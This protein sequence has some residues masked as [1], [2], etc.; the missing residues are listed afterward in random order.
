MAAPAFVSYTGHTGNPTTSATVTLPT[1][2]ANDILILVAVNAGAITSLT[3][4]GTYSG[5]AWTSIDSGAGTL[6]WGGFWWSRC[7]GN[8]TG[9]TVTVST[10]VDSCSAAIMRISG[11][12]T[13]GSPIDTNKSG[14]TIAANGMSLTG[15]NTTVA[16]TLVVFGIAADDNITIA[17]PTKGATAMDLRGQTSSTGGA[18]SMVG[19]ATLAQAASGATGNFT[20]NH[21]SA[22][23]KRLAAFA[24]TPPAAA[25]L[26]RAAAI[27]ATGLVATAGTGFSVFERATALSASASA[28]SSGMVERPRAASL[29]ATTG[30]AS[31]PQRDLQRAAA[32]AASSAVTTQ[33]DVEA[34][35]S[36]S[37]SAASQVQSAAQRDL[38]RA[39][40]L[41]AVGAIASAAT[42]W[43]E[44]ERSVL[45]QATG[46]VSTAGQT[47]SGSTAHERSAALGAQGV[48]ATAWML[49]RLRSAAIGAAAGLSATG[50]VVR[51]FERMASLSATASL[52][53]SGG[54]PVSRW[55]IDAEA[56]WA[57]TA[58]S[59]WD[60]DLQT[61]R[62]ED[63]DANW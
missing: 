15:F 22:L 11:A 46:V 57:H 62:P 48:I 27:A 24:I 28:A 16:D 52:A 60:P 14:T 10:A 37:L 61:R 33:G 35:R 17:N 23:S 51:L 39:A 8:H 36:A 29:T 56:T 54:V 47:E 18:D 19:L 20:G 2:A 34:L 7:T 53:T 6:Q 38:H 41:G 55:E 5:G 40:G 32:A 58:G 9:Q 12:L 21:A 26:E 49:E 43:S 59:V 30:L 50:T 3:P 25:T 42:F 45:V 31:T 63:T 44:L 13:S 1:T 4:G